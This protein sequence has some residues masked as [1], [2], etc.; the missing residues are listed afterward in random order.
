MRLRLAAVLALTALV[1]ACASPFLPSPAPVRHTLPPLPRGVIEAQPS[2]APRLPPA[3]IADLAIN[4]QGYCSQTEAD[5]FRENATLRVRDSRVE[6][7][8]WELQVGRRGTCR[9]EQADFEQTQSRPHIEMQARDGSGCKLMVW[10]DNRRIT[11]AH[12][13]CAARCTPGIYEDAWP[14]MFDPVSGRCARP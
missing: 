10:R 7:L 1:A 3:P 5:G 8:S 2:Y 13:G 14:V 9:F 4:L 11:L 6:T 12:A